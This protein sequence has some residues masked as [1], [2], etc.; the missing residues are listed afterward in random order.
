MV[1]LHSIE[2]LKDRRNIKNK[3]SAVKNI[4]LAKQRGKRAEDCTSWESDFLS[5]EAYDDSTAIAYDGYCYIFK[6]D[7][8]L[9]MYE[10]P[11]WFGKK[12]HFNGKERIR[13]YKKYCKN[14][15]SY[16]E[17]EMFS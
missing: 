16:L 15:S 8:C 9:T 12:K 6:D 10:L 4:Y 14:N 1:T 3:K 7:V 2:R 13:D 11:S 5:T 17:H